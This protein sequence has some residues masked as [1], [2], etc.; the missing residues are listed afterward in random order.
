MARSSHRHANIKILVNRIFQY[1]YIYIIYITYIHA[2]SDKLVLFY[3]K[4]EIGN[5]SALGKKME[6]GSNG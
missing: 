4:Q 2:H 5:A 3:E 1:C 6:N